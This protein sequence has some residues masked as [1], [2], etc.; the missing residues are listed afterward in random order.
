MGG[1]RVN[2]VIPDCFRNQRALEYVEEENYHD[3]HILYL[4]L[5]HLFG[6]YFSAQNFDQIP[7]RYVDKFRGLEKVSFPVT[8]GGLKKL[9]KVNRHLPVTIHV[10]SHRQ[11]SITDLGVIS[12][13]K[14]EQQAPKERI[15]YLMMFVKKLSAEDAAAL[16]K[17]ICY[18]YKIHDMRKLFN[19]RLW[20]LCPRKTKT[21][22][23]NIRKNTYC[24]SCFARFRSNFKK[25]KHVKTCDKE[26]ILTYP[27]TA[28]GDDTLSFGHSLHL[29]AL[30]VIGFCDFE[31][32]LQR[33]RE[34][35]HCAKCS[36]EECE[37]N[38]SVSRDLEDHRPV[39][40]SILFVDKNDRVFFQEE[41]AGTDC[42]R[43]FLKQ[44]TKYELIVHQRKQLF[45]RKIRASPKDWK[46][47]E[48]AQ[49]CH[50]CSRPFTN[51]RNGRKVVDHDHATGKI[52]GAAHSICNLR[53]QPPS[54]TPIFFHNAQG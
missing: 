52:V 12:N 51:T 50:I 27:D 36:Q 41:Y 8:F 16:D 25:E 10:L 13:Q 17:P 6:E 21:R 20:K 39:G 4:I 37:C 40:Y 9:V 42:A 18:F 49:V 29:Q 23:N 15:L 7:S 11:T 26:Q 24:E 19:F 35:Q 14:K 48:S 47:Y 30:P 28:R 3:R 53:R 5:R 22:Y 1:K 2:R 38:I 46:A 54:C 45:Q 33:R 32:V 34:R 31:S 44:V 43:Y